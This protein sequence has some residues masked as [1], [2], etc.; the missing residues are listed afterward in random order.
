MQTIAENKLNPF[1]YHL[2]EEA[3]KRLRWIYLLSN[4]QNGNVTKAAKK[5]GISR[6]WLSTLNA[7]FE[8]NGNDPRSL[9]PESRAPHNIENRER[10][11]KEI[12]QKI[13]E[14]RDATPGWGKEKLAR[15]L[16]RDHRMIV[17]ASTV[18]RYLKKHHRI[19][20]KI[21]EK[22]MRA[23]KC[24]KQR[25]RAQSGHPSLTVK[26]RP[27]KALKDLAPGALIEKDMKFILKQGTFVNTEKYK[28]KE[29]FFYQHTMI[30]SFTRLRALS[31]VKHA[32]SQTAA[33]AYH[34]AVKRFPFPVAC[35][36]TDNG[37]ENG[38]DFSHSLQLADVFQF[39]SSVGTPT[40]NPR[41][42]RSHLSD[43]QEFY[44]R[45]NS[46]LPYEEQQNNLLRWERRY[47]EERPHQALGY[48]TPIEFYALWKKNPEHAH[49]IAKKWKAHLL[50]QRTRL[51]SARRMKRQEQIQALMTFIDAKLNQTVEVSNAKQSLIN[52]QLCSW[53]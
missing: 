52:C 39:Y 32:D 27:P 28:A 31:L 26:F 5:I 49:A 21:S 53:T 36:N 18:N 30:D 40:D 9:E 14:V 7:V 29:N 35:M 41:V 4:E 12:E 16:K 46:S 42:E 44:H 43:D 34:K 38:K 13:I 17:G 48:L 45:G 47:N 37:G 51:A 19:D 50:R 15:I 23:W 10:I 3:R 2:S 33:T 24:K 25:E 11:P 1:R 22:N 20:P 8:R 6:Q